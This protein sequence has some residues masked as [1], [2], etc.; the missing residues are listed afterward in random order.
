V[1]QPGAAHDAGPEPL[2]QHVEDVAH[3]GQLGASA[4]PAAVSADLLSA[5]R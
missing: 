2:V 3:V 5:L 1:F 4:R